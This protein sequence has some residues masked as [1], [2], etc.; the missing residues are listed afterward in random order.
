MEL[1]LSGLFLEDSEMVVRFN[2]VDDYRAL[3]LEKTENKCKK[4]SHWNLI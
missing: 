1:K 4:E 2:F 3:K